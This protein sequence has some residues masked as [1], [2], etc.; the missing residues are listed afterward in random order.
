MGL[1]KKGITMLEVIV[2]LV[3]MG[4]TSVLVVPGVGRVVGRYR[5]KTAARELSNFM[6]DEMFR[7]PLALIFSKA[8]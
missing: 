6:L 8:Y 3:V 2:V 4:I 7:V 5:L 1:N